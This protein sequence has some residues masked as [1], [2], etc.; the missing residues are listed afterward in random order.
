MYPTSVPTHSEEIGTSCSST[1]AT[2]TTGGGGAVAAPDFSP[3]PASAAASTRVSR[4]APTGESFMILIVCTAQPPR[5]R[6]GVPVASVAS[7][8]PDV[9]NARAS[10]GSTYRP[11]DGATTGAVTAELEFRHFFDDYGVGLLRAAGKYLR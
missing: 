11:L 9:T 6:P 7:G 1:D 4:R 2:L 5:R 10:G 3:Q 8:H